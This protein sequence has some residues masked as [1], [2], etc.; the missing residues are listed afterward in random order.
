MLT[1]EWIALYG[2]SSD[3]YTEYRHIIFDSR[4]YID[5]N[6]VLIIV[7]WRLADQAQ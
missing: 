4:T 7:S 3:Y 2:I 5:G 1:V 6:S